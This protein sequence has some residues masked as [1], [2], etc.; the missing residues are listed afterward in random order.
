MGDG[1]ENLAASDRA[2]DAAREILL[3]R[4]KSVEQKLDALAEEVDPKGVHRLRVSTRRAGAA[5]RVF[6]EWTPKKERRALEDR[7]RRVRRCAGDARECDVQLEHFAALLD[8]TD[9]GLGSAI[10]F[11]LGTLA[12]RRE[13]AVGRVRE[14]AS[15][16]KRG[17]AT[18]R[19]PRKAVIGSLDGPKKR[20]FLEV[21]RESF[22]R[23]IERM[24][25]ASREDLSVLANLHELRIAGKRLRYT[26]EVVEPCFAPGMFETVT[27][28]MTE[29]QDH[30][31]GLNDLSEMKVRVE[32]L[33]EDS[34]TPAAIVSGLKRLALDLSGRIDREQRA[35]L[36]WWSHAGMHTI[37]GSP[38]EGAGADVNGSAT[39]S[40]NGE[41]SG[42]MESM[43]RDAA[44]HLA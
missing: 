30:L 3:D 21:A 37:L 33:A 12:D 28:R 25:R 38:V 9:P 44:R 36:E 13:R 1:S 11:V 2:S 19:K 8:R 18:I 27:Q 32:A 41:L 29:F 16:R 39:A 26:A 34:T 4:L 24:T 20:T 42:A 22:G 35:F 5:L 7:L 10:G 40:P 14:L 6:R 31:G 15:D 23:E 43:L 17:S